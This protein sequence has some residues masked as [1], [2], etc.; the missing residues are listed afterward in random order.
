MS[1]TDVDET[2]TEETAA[3]VTAETTAAAAEQTTAAVETKTL[4]GGAEE[5]ALAVPQDFP[6]DWRQKLA[7]EDKKALKTLERFASV[8]DLWGAL[9]AATA[10]LDS[11][12][13]I[14]RPA[15]RATP[16]EL[17]AFN[18]AIGVPEDAG[19]YIE[20]LKLSND[21]VLGDDDKPVLE[22]FA[23]AIHQAGATP[24]MFNAATDWWFDYQQAVQEAQLESDADFRV[25]SEAVL[26]QE[27]GGDYRR[28]VGA[29]PTLFSNTP[30]EV[31]DLLLN[32]RTADG[33]LLGNH[34]EVVKWL[35]SV[36]SELYPAASM[37]MPDG[38]AAKGIDNE[39]AEIEQYMHTNRAAYF[40][41]EKRQARYRELLAVREAISARRTAA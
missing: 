31:Q 17:A 29:I 20:K 32:G 40:K 3:A 39:I 12:A 27:L 1:V 16:E 6:D 11:G 37:H 9:K 30:S 33:K 28:T 23:K 5:T 13:Y 2:V 19:E 15:T 10:K 14:R 38:D 25:Q 21:R 8:S 41:D 26:K 35:A 34:P 24:Q 22:S 18:K 7:G 36:A 4:A